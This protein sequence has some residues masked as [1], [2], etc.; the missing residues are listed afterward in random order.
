MEIMQRK[1]GTPQ[2]AAD[3]SL[4]AGWE[5]QEVRQKPHQVGKGSC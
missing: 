3:G 2:E 1:G 5:C 4:A